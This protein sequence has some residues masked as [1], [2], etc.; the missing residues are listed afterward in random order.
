MSSP[1]DADQTEVRQFLSDLL[2]QNQAMADQIVALIRQVA[3][4]SAQ[5]PAASSPAVNPQ[6]AS[7]ISSSDVKIPSPGLTQ[8]IRKNVGVSSISVRCSLK[9]PPISSILDV[10]R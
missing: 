6:P 9:W 1:Q 4:L 8:A 2:Q 10:R 3:V 5:V 7:A